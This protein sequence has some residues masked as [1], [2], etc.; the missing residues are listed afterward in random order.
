N[1]TTDPTGVLTEYNALWTQ[2]AAQFQCEP[3]KLV[4]ESVNE[5]S[6]SGSPS[7]SQSAQM[8]NQLN[9]AFFDDVR[10]SGGNNAKR[11][12]LL[13]RLGDTPTQPLMDNLYSTI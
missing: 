7:D 3:N 12:P 13:P 2:I 6:F 10:A 8:L 9:T 1:M 4:L 5:P 11:L